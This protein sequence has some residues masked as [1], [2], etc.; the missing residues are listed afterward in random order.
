MM[1]ICRVC[2]LYFASNSSTRW[3]TKQNKK[4]KSFLRWNFAIIA[5]IYI[6]YEYVYENDQPNKQ[7]QIIF[8]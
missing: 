8:I 7:E 1:R 5:C 3:L 2:L 6:Y 4:Q